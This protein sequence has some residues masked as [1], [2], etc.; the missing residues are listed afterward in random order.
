LAIL[1]PDAIPDDAIERGA[2]V[3]RDAQGGDPELILIGTG[4]EVSLCLDAADAL[5]G[6]R[7]RVVSMPCM[8]TFTRAEDAYREQVL[9]SACRA[10]IAVEAASPLGWDR[11]IGPDGAFVGMETFGESGPAKEVYE[12]FGITAERV[13]SLG[14]ELVQRAK[15]AT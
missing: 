10:R 6:V 12:H 4:S 11:W 3:L 8:D 7:V 9:P 2:Y 1:D 13:A 15:E 14:R 5:E